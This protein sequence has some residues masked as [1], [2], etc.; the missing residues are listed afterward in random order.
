MGYIQVMRRGALRRAT[1][2]VAAAAQAAA[3]GAASASA[4]QYGAQWTLPEA[5]A[6]QGANPGGS[7]PGANE[8]GCKPTKAHP[9]P[10][11]LVHGLLANQAVNWNVTTMQKSARELK[12]LIGRVKRRTGAAKVD[13][14]DHSEGSIMPSWCVRFLGGGNVV[15][16]Y[17]GAPAPRTRSSTPA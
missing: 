12:R 10:V 14:V 6:A 2:A 15:D 7:P 9:E 1:I 4:A 8:F 3:C 5:I 17:V 13:I 16:D 11:V